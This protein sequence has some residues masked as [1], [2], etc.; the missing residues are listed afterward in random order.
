M[1]K[2]EVN[3]TNEKQSLLKFI[4]ELILNGFDHKKKNIETL[5]LNEF[6]CIDE[7]K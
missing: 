1:L 6:E 4:N 5:Y 2:E 3:L 7:L